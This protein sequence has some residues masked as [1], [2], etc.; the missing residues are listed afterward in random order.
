MAQ[1]AEGTS[2]EHDKCLVKID[3]TLIFVCI[4]KKKT[5]YTRFYTI[6]GFRHPLRVLGHILYE[7]GGSVY[8]CYSCQKFIC[9]ILTVFG[10]THNEYDQ[11]VHF[12]CCNQ[13]FTGAWWITY[14]AETWSVRLNHFTVRDLCINRWCKTS[15]EEAGY[16][17][18]SIGILQAYIFISQPYFRWIM[19]LNR[20]QR[21]N[22]S[23]RCCKIKMAL[24][25]YNGAAK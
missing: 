3:M 15:S 25:I 22:A 2:I 10:N 8:C 14:K 19:K 13:D 18:I 24:A 4:H 1:T 9:Y 21:G 12:Q 6:C 5:E 20:S 17:L 7:K 23:C 16:Y 11:V